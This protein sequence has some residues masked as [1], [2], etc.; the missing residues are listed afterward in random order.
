MQQKASVAAQIKQKQELVSL[1]TGYLKIHRHRRGN[2]IRR[3]EKAYGS[4][5]T[6]SKTNVWAIGMQEDF[7]ILRGLKVHSERW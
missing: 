4:S 2:K 3:D 6:I 1:K 5:E 7:M